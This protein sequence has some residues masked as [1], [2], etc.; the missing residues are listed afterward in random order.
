MPD[1]VLSCQCELSPLIAKQPHVLGTIF[2]PVLLVRNLKFRDSKSLFQ[3]HTVG[4][5]VQELRVESRRSDFEP[6]CGP[7][8]LLHE[9]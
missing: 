4:E 9:A 3:C 1:S 6:C 5:T 2:I 8:H 7:G